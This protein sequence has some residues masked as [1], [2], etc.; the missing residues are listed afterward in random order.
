MKKIIVSI[1][2][3]TLA[4]TL[5]ACDSQTNEEGVVQ[6][7]QEQG[8]GS[9]NVFEVELPDGRTVLC[10]SER[11]SERR[12]GSGGLSCDWDNAN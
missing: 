9:I 7:N 2:A 6:P 4:F 3:I 11:V 1:V 5:G 12:G 10:V 8:S